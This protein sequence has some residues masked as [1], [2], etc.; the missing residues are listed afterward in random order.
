MPILTAGG[1]ILNIG[2]GVASIPYI[3]S[4]AHMFI[5]TWDTTWTGSAN[6]VIIIPSA[7]IVDCSIYWDTQD[8]SRVTGTPGNIVHTYATPGEKTIKI[9]GRFDSIAFNDTGDKLKLKYIDNWGDIQWESLQNAFGGCSSMNGRYTD[10][11]CTASCT[12]MAYMFYK[13]RSFNA[14]V[15]FDTHNVTNM[16]GM[17]FAC[18]SF[19]Q[20]ISSFN[21][22][23]VTDFSYF[24]NSPIFNQPVS[25]FDTSAATTML[26]MFYQCYK[27][28]QSVS[29][30]KT[31]NVTD[32]N[33]MFFACSSFNQPVSNFNTS[34]VTTMRYMFY[35]CDSFKQDVSHLNIE[36]ISASTGIGSMFYDTDINDTGTTTNYDRLLISWAAQN[37]SSNLQFDIRPAKYSATGL[38]ARNYLTGTKGWTITDGGMDDAEM[39]IT[40]WDTTWTG[41]ANDTIII[42]TTGLGYNC[43]IY[44]DT[45]DVSKVS[46]T[47]GNIVH[48]YATPG[49]KTIK[50]E[51][52]FPRIY[53]N[54][55]GDKLKLK[56]I[57]NWGDTQWASFNSAF[58][59]CSSM[60]GRYTDDPCT[61]NVTS[62]ESM[63]TSCSLFNSSVNF[64]TNNATSMRSMFSYCASFNQPLIT[65]NTSN[66]TNISNMLFGCESFNQPVSHF[67]T[68]NVTTMIYMFYNCTVFN[69]SVSNFDTAD[70]SDM[71]YMFYQCTNFNQPL[72]NFNTANVTTMYRMFYNCTS[73][74]QDVSNFSLAKAK[75]VSLMFGLCDINGVGTTTN[76]DRLLM[77]WAGQDVPNDLTFSGGNSKYSATDGS[78]ARNSL[79]TDDNWIIADG[80]VG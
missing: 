45:Q 6:N 74:K 37:V 23:K 42:P 35:D 53:F 5:T 63:F 2:G 61:K 26:A 1:K 69:Q 59:G 58:R 80:G 70:V 78:T 7:G 40:T 44:W 75:D 50:I 14:P 39:F 28:N 21:T 31:H 8:V 66:V 48:T 79:I 67:N 76:Y 19:N 54:N 33:S 18:P 12:H 46:G 73:F 30:F 3:S 16:A 9:E 4:D 72:Y 15:N 49:E 34:K 60:N 55:T 29:N 13:C 41:S 22:A 11:P 56:Y 64:W 10:D 57:D 62:F 24:M 36:K 43:S 27:F 20:S 17:F 32:M 65:F 52:T 77:S 25:N 51:G 47:P 38:S 71:S 68:S